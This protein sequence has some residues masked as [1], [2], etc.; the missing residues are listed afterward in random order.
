MIELNY[1]AIIAAAIAS[2]L[3]GWLWYGPLFGKQW[4]KLAGLKKSDMKKMKKK[5]GA[6]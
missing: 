5:A 3:I 1:L 6:M 4:M 2:M